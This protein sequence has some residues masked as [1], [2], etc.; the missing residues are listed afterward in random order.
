METTQK[1]F[2][3]MYVNDTSAKVIKKLALEGKMTRYN[4]RTIAWKI[5]LGVLPLPVNSV[6]TSKM[7]NERKRY[8]ELIKKYENETYVVDP[9]L[10]GS[11]NNERDELKKKIKKDIDR[12]YNSIEFYCDNEIRTKISNALYIFAREHNDLGYQQGFH[13]IMGIFIRELVL[14]SELIQNNTIERGILHTVICLNEIEADTFILFEKLMTILGVFYE[15][16]RIKDSS[17]TSLIHFKCE[18]LFQSIAKYDPKYFATLIRHNIVPAVFGLRWIRMLYA[19]EF[20]I[21]DVVIL[22]DAIFAFGHQL[23]LVDSLFIVMMLYVRNDIVE[24]DDESYSLRRLMKY[25]PVED[26]KLLIELAVALA[27][28]RVSISGTSICMRVDQNSL[29]V[30]QPIDW[31]S[32][33]KCSRDSDKIEESLLQKLGT[34][35]RKLVLVD[36]EEKINTQELLNIASDLSKIIDTMK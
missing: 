22:W 34:I 25:P 2:E 21:D 14:D 1:I 31:L 6:W 26:I 30:D 12:L 29:L 5:W 11:S 20:H 10:S 36:R 33:K 8:H 24:R 32:K 19:R 27:E 28:H 18:K 9:L 35:Q 23:K 15:Q 4:L 7:N 16:K 3:T 17:T 13:E